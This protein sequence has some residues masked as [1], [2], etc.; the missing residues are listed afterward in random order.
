MKYRIV[1]RPWL[2]P[3]PYCLE[4]LSEGGEWEFTARY[5]RHLGEVDTFIE[6][7][8]RGEYVAREFEL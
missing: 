8:K 6:N 3:E 2:D 7:M 1:F 5:F 4:K